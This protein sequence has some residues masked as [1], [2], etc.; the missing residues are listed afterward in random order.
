VAKELALASIAMNKLADAYTLY[1]DIDGQNPE[2]RDIKLS[3]LMHFLS[4]QIWQ[5]NVEEVFRLYPS[6]VEYCKHSVI[7]R[8]FSLGS[9]VSQ[10]IYF[11]C[12]TETGIKEARNLYDNLPREP[13]MLVTLARTG[14]F[15][16]EYYVKNSQLEEARKFFASM[17]KLGHIPKIKVFVPMSK[18]VKAPMVQKFVNDAK[19]IL[20]AADPEH[21]ERPK[22]PKSK[23]DP[24]SVEDR[25]VSD[26]IKIKLMEGNITE[27][28]RLLSILTSD[29]KVRKKSLAGV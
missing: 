4:E 5:N 3:F 26:Q 29:R 23:P 6:I 9:A 17:A 22:R 12:S 25:A 8:K 15:F 18:I 1:D 19:K 20:D 16:I 28:R 10:I 7:N 13:V 21:I 11:C 14:I 27:A 24:F 2:V